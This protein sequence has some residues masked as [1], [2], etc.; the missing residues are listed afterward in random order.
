MSEQNEPPVVIGVV[1]E[2]QVS[3]AQVRPPLHEAYVGCGVPQVPVTL[4]ASTQAPER[5]TRPLPQRTPAQGSVVAA[6]TQPEAERASKTTM[7]V[8]M[9]QSLGKQTWP[10]AP[11]VTSVHTPVP[12]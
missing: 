8:R 1:T 6:T 11:P 2:M 7:A 3:V 5:Q 12:G 4:H 9:A 10:T